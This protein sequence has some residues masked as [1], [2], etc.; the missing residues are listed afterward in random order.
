MSLYLPLK[1]NQKIS[2]K[3]RTVVFFFSPAGI[4]S[5]PVKPPHT[6]GPSLP[7]LSLAQV[8]LDYAPF[9]NSPEALARSLTSLKPFPEQFSRFSLDS[10]FEARP[11]HYCIV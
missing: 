9:T 4:P 7:S 10:V 11:S 3:P 8:A 2:P 6:D 1:S 5:P